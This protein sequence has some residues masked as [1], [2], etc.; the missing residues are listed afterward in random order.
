M[1]TKH[2]I[3]ETFNIILLTLLISITSCN[4]ENGNLTPAR[5]IIGTWKTAIPVKFFIE[6]NFCTG[7]FNTVAT[8][9][10]EV[11]FIIT[12]GDN[13]NN[14]NIEVRFVGSNFTRTDFTYASCIGANTGYVPEVS[15]NF[16]SGTIS[17]VNLTITGMGTFSFTTDNMMGT[18]DKSGKGIFDQRVYTET[19]QLKLY[20]Q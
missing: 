12:K 2:V 6:T 7:S 19:N 20:K 17:G 5:S 4:S 11:T 1:K 9:N 14:V 3:N 16:Y 18:Y 8:E 10:R 15:P 13:E